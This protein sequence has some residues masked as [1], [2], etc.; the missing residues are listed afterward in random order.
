M[1]DEQNEL[2]LD[3]LTKKAVYGLD[4]LEQTELERFKSEGSELDFESFEFAAAAIGISGASPDEK[5]PAHLRNSIL[6]DA[7]AFFEQAKTGEKT[8]AEVS[9]P[10]F[11]TYSGKPARQVREV[12]TE[13]VPRRGFFNWLGWAAAA[14]ACIALAVNLWFTRFQ[15]RPPVEQGNIPQATPT[16]EK[17]SPEQMYAELAKMPGI[18]KAS[19]SLGNVKDMKQ[20]GGDVVWS[21]EKQMGYMRFQ[22]LPVNDAAKETYQLWIFDKSRDETYPI[23]GGT[24][25]VNSNGEVIVPINAKLKAKRP[26]MFAVTLEKPGG[27]VVSKKEKIAAL[28]TVAVVEKPLN[29]NNKTN[30]AGKSSKTA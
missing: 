14:A 17:P 19:W 16:P 24:F 10:I 23:D 9:E 26:N 3:L 11:S 13:T 8:T 12:E 1:N 4:A 15:P 18:V 22:G 29:T 21:E 20:I 28:A 2:L 5:M 27:V 7:D 25:D 30:T 6:A